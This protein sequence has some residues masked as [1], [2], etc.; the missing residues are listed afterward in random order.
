[1]RRG[2]GAVGAYD[3]LRGSTQAKGFRGHLEALRSGTV[4]SG[5]I[6]IAGVGASALSASAI[7]GRR[8]R[9]GFADRVAGVSWTRR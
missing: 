5:T 9:R 2:A 1:L 7:I 4:T 3:D 8:R 6:K